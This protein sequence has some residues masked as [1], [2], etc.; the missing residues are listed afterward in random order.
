M[1]SNSYTKKQYIIN[2]FSK[3]NKKNY[4][5]YVITRIIHLLNDLDIKFVTQ[6][7]FKRKNGSFGLSDLYFP[8]FNLSIE[9][10]E[11]HHQKKRN[12]TRDFIRD[13]D[14]IDAT[15]NLYQHRKEW[16][17]YRIN[18][19]GDV[20]IEQ[21]NNE[22]QKVV[23]YIK[24]LKRK[25]NSFQP[26]DVSKEFDYSE[27]SVFDINDQI[28]FKR[29]V[30]AINYFRLPGEKYKGYQR[31]GALTIDK[32][33]KLWFPKLYPNEHWKNKLS[34]NEMIIE[35]I[36]ADNEKWKKRNHLDTILSK[37]DKKRIVFARVKGNLGFVLYRFK[38]FYVLNEAKSKKEGFCVWERKSQKVTVPFGDPL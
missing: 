28:V 29:I 19:D 16:M 8:Q 9:I 34:D 11:S 30:D 5:N 33:K 35:E 18:V 10:D 37:N 24:L 6:Q 15:D 25:I 32:K 13:L 2:Q 4:E 27:R 20:R 36:P 7:Y 1:S 3:T 22:V 14:Y 23:D 26:W 21:I 12:M 17:P 38:G 31:A